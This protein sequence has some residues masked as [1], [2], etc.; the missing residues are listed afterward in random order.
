MQQSRIDKARIVEEQVRMLYM[1]A[2]I[3]NLVSILI[4]GIFFLVLGSNLGFLQTGLWATAITLVSL[5]R[6]ALWQ[7]HTRRP[8]RRSAEQW[9]RDYAVLT[10]L[11]G[12]F[13]SVLYLLT[14][15][16]FEMTTLGAMLLLWFGL[17]GGAFSILSAHLPSY[18]LFTLPA[19]LAFSWTL[20]RYPEYLSD[21]L[22]ATL[23]IFY[24][25]LGLFA[26]NANRRLRHN[27]GLQIQ[28]DVLLAQMRDE[29]SIRDQLVEQQTE[30]LRDATAASVR[31][32]EQLQHVINGANLGFWDWE[33][34]TGN[35]EVNRRWR[36][37]LGLQQSDLRN[38]VSDWSERVHP[39]DRTRMVDLVEKHIA[40]RTSYA[41]D[42]RMRHKDGHWVWIQGAGGVVEYDAEGNPVRL[43]GTHQ[44]ISDRKSLE[45]QLAYQ[46]THDPL[47]GLFNR[48]ELWERLEGEISRAERYGQKL[49]VFLVDIDHFKQVNDTYGHKQ[50]DRL[51]ETFALRLREDMRKMDMCGRY[52]GEEFLVLLPE[53]S[54]ASAG[55]RAE[56]LRA[57]VADSPVKL[58]EQ[59]V[60]LTISIGVAAYPDHGR[61]AG[62]LID[63]ADRALY[64][65]KHNGRNR[66]EL[67]N[68]KPQ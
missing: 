39:E 54:A 24:I 41:A 56:R 5:A 36:E 43:C 26:L 25:M 2:L 37:M 27:L 10:S 14:P 11:L 45:Q 60:E 35:H 52:G 30:Q 12:L 1:Q 48:G 20:A 40:E 17:I 63:A 65:A 28:N 16:Q 51:L 6:I 31:S 42:F 22:I 68:D 49:A 67:A 47:T 33:Y 3:S 9:L 53:I 58:D 32:Q 46:A 64:R 44:E 57:L 55:E 15:A 61:N 34:K 59:E 4:A 62:D 50:G 38:D 21:V 18:F 13:W 19:L 29:V 8:N 66:I 23:W 7:Q